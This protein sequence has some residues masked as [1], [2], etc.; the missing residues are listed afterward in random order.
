MNTIAAAN[1]SRPRWPDWWRMILIGMCALALCSCQS[2]VRPAYD[3]SALDGQGYPSLPPQAFTGPMG[4]PGM[5]QGVPLAYAPG[6]PWSP[7]GISQPWPEDEYLRDG[8]DRGLPVEV[9]E[10]WE[11]NG[12]ELEDTIA[13]YDTLDGETLVQPSN[14]VHIYSPRFGAVRQVVGLAANEQANRSAGV[15]S[16][17]KLESPT[18]VQ[19]VA[20]NKQHIQAGRQVGRRLASAFR[21]KW[22]NGTL[23]DTVG[24]EAFQDAF[25]AYEDFQLIRTGTVA[26]GETAFLARGSQ[27]AQAWSLKQ[28]V[29]VI[30]DEQAA[31]AEVSDE[32][33]YS[34]HTVKS[35]PGKPKLRVVKVASTQFASPGDE[36]AFTIRF[37]NI[38]DQVIGNVTIVDNLTTRLEY[39]P[40][41]AQCSVEAEFSTQPNEG[42]SLVL[43]CE[44]ANPLPVCE[45]AVIRFRC[46]V[47]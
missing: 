21:T 23:S 18:I 39:I 47:R 27:A 30:L 31:M 37:D 15:Y 28:A 4:P 24:P 43:R 45:G 8:G 38:G 41:S 10:E 16:P 14:R 46:R 5:E 32:S 29:Q 7:P 19:L 42:D 40:D 34:V 13:H 33:L 12:L 20:D 6:G 11:I 9:S 2:S 36:V 35:P 25:R 1:T 44:V 22:G 17:V 26:A 3:A